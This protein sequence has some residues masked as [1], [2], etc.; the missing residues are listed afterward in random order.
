MVAFDTQDGTGREYSAASYNTAQAAGGQRSSGASG[1]ARGRYPLTPTA[2]GARGGM[3]YVPT[4]ARYLDPS[5][6]PMEQAAPEGPSG[7]VGPDPATVNQRGQAITLGASNYYSKKGTPGLLGGYFDAFKNGLQGAAQGYADIAGQDFK[8]Q[9]GSMLG[10]LNSI[11]ALRSGGVQAGIN[12][13]MTTYGRQ[14]GDY[15]NQLATQA[16][17]LAQTE[18]DNN[19]ERQF[20]DQQ[21]GDAKKAA[22]KSAIGNILGGL[23]GAVSVIPGIGKIGGG[24]LKGLGSIFG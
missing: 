19:I 5:V 16:A 9:V 22:H 11:G 20:R 12:Q 21:Y 8:Q 23:G 15:S 4:Y 2:V 6:R 17:Q 10:D 3:S 18:N 14:V 13:A 7:P 24:I 1:G